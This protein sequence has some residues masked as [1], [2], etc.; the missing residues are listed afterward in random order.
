[1][2][3][4]VMVEGE[5]MGP[6]TWSPSLDGRA[7]PGTK[8]PLCVRFSE[9]Q[10][11]WTGDRASGT[12]SAMKWVGVIILVVVGLIAAF[13]AIEYFTVQI[14]ALPSYLPGR[15]AIKYGHY[16]K[17][18][19]VAALI[20]IIAFVVAGVLAVRIQRGNQSPIASAGDVLAA[21]SQGP[22]TPAAPAASPEEPTTN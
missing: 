17:R 18:G 13:V 5:T 12:L 4:P 11:L 2:T 20:A 8:A 15:V 3:E 22:A 19:A 10:H 9:Q 21:A 7:G 6:T 1:M 14:H 16:R